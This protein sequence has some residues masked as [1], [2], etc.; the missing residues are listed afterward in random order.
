MSVLANGAGGRQFVLVK[1]APEAVLA[2]C[3]HALING[4]GGSGAGSGAGGSGSGSGGDGIVGGAPAAA[5]GDGARRA[6]LAR[7]ERF[8]GAPLTIA[9]EGEGR[10]AGMFGALAPLPR[11]A[12]CIAQT[13][14]LS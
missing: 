5:L 6:L 3:S 12:V 4:G 13:C 9:V 1:G 10:R 2:R 7:V 8:G 11:A 14:N